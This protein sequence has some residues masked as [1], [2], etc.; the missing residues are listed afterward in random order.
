MTNQTNSNKPDISIYTRVAQKDGQSRLGSQIGVGFKHKGDKQGF[1]IYLDAQ[2][3][4]LDGRIELVAF[5]NSSR[6]G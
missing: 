4:P 5:D 1:N 2:P 3:I 6:E